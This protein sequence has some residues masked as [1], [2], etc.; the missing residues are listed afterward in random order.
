[1]LSVISRNNSLD[2]S[3]V[4]VPGIGGI[5]PA[6]NGTLPPNEIAICPITE[7]EQMIDFVRIFTYALI[8]SL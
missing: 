4:V 7:G 8:Y 2:S 6:P 1:M 3:V 5:S